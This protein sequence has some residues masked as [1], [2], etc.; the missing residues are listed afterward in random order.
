MTWAP[1]VGISKYP[2][3]GGSDNQRAVFAAYTS[4]F[5]AAEFDTFPLFYADN[6]T[7][8]LPNHGTFEGRDAIVG[9]YKKMFPKIRESLAIDHLIADDDGIC[10]KITSTFAAIKDTTEYFGD[11]KKGGQLS[12]KVFVVYGLSEGLIKSIDVGRR[13]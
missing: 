6:V 1:G 13:D 4:A 11:F 12:I 9:F 7:L 8:Q 5:S 10:A 2:R 3:L